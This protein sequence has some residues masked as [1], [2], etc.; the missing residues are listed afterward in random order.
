MI[1]KLVLLC[2]IAGITQ[3]CGRNGQWDELRGAEKRDLPSINVNGKTYKVFEL[4]RSSNPER[5]AQDDP[6]ATFAVYVVVG[7]GKS[8][9]C[10]RNAAR[11]KNVIQKLVAKPAKAKAKPK[12]EVQKEVLDGM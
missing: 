8:V 6:N 12:P 5:R 1:R 9:Y 2:L 11:C 7:P 10:G 4:S 3:G